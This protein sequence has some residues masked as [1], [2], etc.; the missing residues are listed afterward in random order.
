ME[1]IINRDIYLSVFTSMESGE[2]GNGGTIALLCWCVYFLPI[3]V[4]A[5]KH[6]QKT[7]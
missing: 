1:K 5:Y 6:F 2:T 7:Q 4:L 3:G